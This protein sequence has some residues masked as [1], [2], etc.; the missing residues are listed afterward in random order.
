MDCLPCFPPIP[1]TGFRASCRHKRRP[2][3]HRE[4]DRR[5]FGRHIKRYGRHN[6]FPCQQRAVARARDG[7]AAC[8]G[9]RTGSPS[10][11][12]PQGYQWKLEGKKEN[13]APKTLHDV[14]FSNKERAPVRIRPRSCCE[15]K[16]VLSHL[17]RCRVPIKLSFSA[18]GAVFSAKKWGGASSK[19][20]ACGP[21]F[22]SCDQR[23][24]E[25]LGHMS[26]NFPEIP[27]CF[28]RSFPEGGTVPA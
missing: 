11:I 3:L 28:S 24:W 7:K 8:Q 6:I 23:G 25:E 21:Q 22:V 19:R 10:K 12:R 27:F 15:G 26:L 20:A 17:V 18:K 4:G 13:S 9:R 2:P 14:S 16:I 5:C 1:E